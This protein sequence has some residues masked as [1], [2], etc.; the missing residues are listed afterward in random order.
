LVKRARFVTPRHHFLE[1]FHLSTPLS[2]HQ[3]SISKDESLIGGSGSSMEP[4]LS[5]EHGV[6]IAV[7][8][9]VCFDHSSTIP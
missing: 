7:E 6:R 8:G 5:E 9:C 2:F 3:L 4:Q 1:I